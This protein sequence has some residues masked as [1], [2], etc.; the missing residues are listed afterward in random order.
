M[1]MIINIKSSNHFSQFIVMVVTYV[2][3][4]LCDGRGI[5]SVI[6]AIINKGRHNVGTQYMT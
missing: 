5:S 1:V 6:F 4:S 2:C 3:I